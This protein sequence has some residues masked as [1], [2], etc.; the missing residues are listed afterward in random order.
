MFAYNAK[1]A[2]KSLNDRPSLTILMVAAIA[3]GLGLF[4][5]MLTLSHQASKIPIP[6]ISEQ[7]H[8]VQLDNREVDAEEAERF[9]EMVDLTYQDTE[10]LLN[11]DIAGVQQSLAWNTHGIL[12]V[13]EQ[14]I[15]PLRS[16][17]VAT[18]HAFF[19]MFDVPFLYGNGWDKAADQYGQSVIVLSKASNDYLFGGTN[20]VGQQIRLNTQV[21]TVVGVLDD[22][23]LAQ[24]FYDRS[25]SQAR[26]DQALIPS[27]LAF[28]N[29]LPRN[30]RFDCWST[31]SNP[32]KFMTN[33]L[34][35]LKTS[36]C[37]WI[38]FWAKL[39]SN[40]KEDYQTLLGQYIDSQ[41]IQ[42][43]LTS[44]LNAL[45]EG[46]A[47]FISEFFLIIFMLVFLVPLQ[48]I[49]LTTI[50]SNKKYKHISKT[51]FSLE[52]SIFEYF[53]SKT[54]ISFGTAL[55]SF[56]VMFFLGVEYAL[57][58]SLLIFIL[59]FIPTF[60][61]Y[62][63]YGIIFAIYA[64]TQGIDMLFIGLVIG[65]F[66]INIIWGSI[67]E[68]KFTGNKLELSPVVIIVSL[69]FWGFIWGIG[70]MFFAVP[71]TLAI[72]SILET[73]TSSKELLH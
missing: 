49:W 64:I 56:L 12:N 30:A 13:E 1:L 52:E 50:S 54:L 66:S 15:Q 67:I 47:G 69:L 26:P 68:P 3:I 11:M 22:W 23:F 28:N 48:N 21:L 35:E 27:N 20:S 6:H 61:D 45:F 62:I 19:S 37:A 16:S 39:P 38:T 59:N 70:G 57:L 7:I 10:N 33:F 32:R 17:L 41:R 24:K 65:L 53:K 25:Y 46:F 73:S 40:A 8:L 63:S 36:E 72:K 44:T 58:F 51:I 18:N 60:G 31:T 55:S 34:T 42:E 14:D 4:M 43:L 9:Y 29:E 5:T 71:L 2:F